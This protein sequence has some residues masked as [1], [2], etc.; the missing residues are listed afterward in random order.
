MF[1]LKTI[2][3]ASIH[4]MAKGMEQSHCGNPAKEYEADY[5]EY[6]SDYSEPGYSK[7]KQG[8]L[9]GNWNGYPTRLTDILEKLGYEIEWSDEW[10]TCSDCGNAVRTGPDSYSWTQSFVIYNDCEL[11]CHNCVKRN[12]DEYEEYLLNNSKHADTL[13]I[14]WI[15]RGFTLFNPDHYESGLH[16]YQTDKPEEIIKRLPAD[17]DYLFAIA[18]KGQFAVSFD[19]YVRPQEKEED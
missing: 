7:P 4:D 8:I 19:C 2:I 5:I 11:I 17:H 3:L 6:A 1:K 16:A 14:N 15:E 9:F 18:G 13:D 12:L 10:S